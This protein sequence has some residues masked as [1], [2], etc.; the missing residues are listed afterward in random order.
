VDASGA[1][2]D[3]LISPPWFSPA[4]ENGMIRKGFAKRAALG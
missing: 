1:R 3:L 4:S 2:S